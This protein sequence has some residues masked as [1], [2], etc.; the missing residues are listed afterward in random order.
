MA[1]VENLLEKLNLSP[2]EQK[3][4][5]DKISQLDIKGG[6]WSIR[7]LEG[8]QSVIEEEIRKRYNQKI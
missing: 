8:M 6:H 7:H 1:K 5:R 2:N 3:I 4:I